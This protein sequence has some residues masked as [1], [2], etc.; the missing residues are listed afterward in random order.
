MCPVGWIHNC[1]RTPFLAR[2]LQRNHSLAYH[3]QVCSIFHPLFVI[4][5][6]LIVQQHFS[7]KRASLPRHTIQTGVIPIAV[8]VLAYAVIFK[9]LFHL[10]DGDLIKILGSVDGAYFQYLGIYFLII[11]FLITTATV[12]LSWTN[13]PER[14][15]KINFILFIIFYLIGLPAYYQEL[16]SNQDY[17]YLAKAIIDLHKSG[18]SNLQDT[19]LI[20]TPTDATARER[21]LMDN[22]F[23]FNNY[24]DLQIATSRIFQTIT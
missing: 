4:S 5:A 11:I 6:F 24:N 19:I 15:L 12:W 21:A 14:L 3:G 9:N 16:L 13:Q 18:D 20:L 7:F 22:T 23:N 17:Q 1:L 2:A 10:H 8:V